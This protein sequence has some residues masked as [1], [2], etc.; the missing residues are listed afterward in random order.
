MQRVKQICMFFKAVYST[1][2]CHLHGPS[3]YL[4]SLSTRR[5]RDTQTF[6]VGSP[7]AHMCVKD[8]NLPSPV[9][10]YAGVNVTLT[11]PLLVQ[12]ER[13]MC[14]VW[15]PQYKVPSPIYPKK[16]LYRCP[17]VH[18]IRDKYKIMPL[19]CI[20]NLIFHSI[21]LLYLSNLLK[22]IINIKYCVLDSFLKW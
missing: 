15:N 17:K 1:L 3:F 14:R 2:L 19:R 12:W 9:T 10:S 8:K 22:P 11:Q 4:S 7:Y 13:C 18:E 16:W 20:I 6:Y 21:V 5:E